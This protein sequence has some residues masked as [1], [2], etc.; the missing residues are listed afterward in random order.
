MSGCERS[1]AIAAA[2]VECA[3]DLVWVGGMGKKDG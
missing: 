2:L 3:K 1:S